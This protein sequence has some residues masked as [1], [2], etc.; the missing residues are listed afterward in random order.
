[1][2]ADKVKC[3]VVVNNTD[4]EVRLLDLLSDTNT[5]EKLKRDPSS[6]HKTKV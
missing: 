4:Y 1:M 2:P 3:T 6:S 5:N